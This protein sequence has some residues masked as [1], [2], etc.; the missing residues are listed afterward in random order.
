M[1]RSH[2]FAVFALA[3]HGSP[4]VVRE[5][6]EPLWLPVDRGTLATAAPPFP[7]PVGATADD[8][9][10]RVEF[11]GRTI[12]D[13]DKGLALAVFNADGT[14]WRTLEI[15]SGSPLRV[16]SEAAIYELKAESP[17]VEITTD[18]WTDITPV[19][20]T[21]SWLATVPEVGSVTIESE[22]PAASIGPNA[23]IDEMLAAGVARPVSRTSNAEGTVTL[24]TELTRNVYG[25][26]LFRM[27]VDNPPSQ[28]RARVRSGGKESNVTLCAHR[29]APLFATDSDRA[30]V[31]PDFESEA[32]FGSGWR[33]SE[34]TRTGR[35]RRAE[36]RAT[37]L[38]PLAAGYSYQLSLDFA[39]TPGRLDASLNGEM[40]GGCELAEVRTACDVVLPSRIVRDGVNSL[41]LTA[42]PLPPSGPAPMIFQGAHIVR[43]P[44]R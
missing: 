26:P 30:A 7:G 11:G 39:R 8:R 35:V 18:R 27:A 29:P 12:A 1:P 34:R 10:A 13:V 32:Y 40:V 23:G 21:G 3:A 5:A 31:R 33:D 20:S 22:L 4:R 36:G 17:C 24:V 15:P 6:D 28:A 19:L 42:V 41:T 14:L 43:R 38:L 2:P 37:L 9:G 44:E 16:E 25:R